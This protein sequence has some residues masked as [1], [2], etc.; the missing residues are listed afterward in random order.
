VKKLAPRPV[1]LALTLALI[2][3]AIA[4]IEG[5]FDVAEPGGTRATAEEPTTPASP[6][7]PPAR[8]RPPNGA[9]RRAS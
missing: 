6:R 7:R 1:L 4:F 5:R 3:G 2:V 9:A 8:R